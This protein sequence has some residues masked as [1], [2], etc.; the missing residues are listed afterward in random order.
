[1]G[2]SGGGTTS[3][4]PGGGGG[5]GGPGGGGLDCSR[6][7]FE[8][9]L[10]S[11][12]PEVVATINVGDICDVALLSSPTARLVV[13]TRPTGEVLGAITSNWEALIECLARDARFVADVLTANSP[14]RVRVRAL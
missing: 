7:S 1:M 2:G 11:P 14:V 3:S 5:F 13:T 6:I 9:T 12:N 4:G 8:T 10:G